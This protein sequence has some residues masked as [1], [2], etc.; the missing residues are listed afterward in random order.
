[1]KMLNPTDTPTRPTDLIND[2][3]TFRLDEDCIGSVWHSAAG[4][5]GDLT[6]SIADDVLDG[7]TEPLGPYSNVIEARMAVRAEFVDATTHHADRM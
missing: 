5:Y 2:C 7:D 4:W 6:W 1:M 3:E